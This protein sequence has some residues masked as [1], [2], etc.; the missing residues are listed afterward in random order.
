[1]NESERYYFHTDQ[2]EDNP[3]YYFCAR[4]DKCFEKAHFFDPSQHGSGSGE[5][6]PA[7]NFIRDEIQRYESTRRALEHNLWA[8]GFYRPKDANNLLELYMGEVL[9][10]FKN[11]GRDD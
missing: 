4:C 9:K 10:N 2:S 11:G 8:K 6:Y 5:G 1:M 7:I 3:N